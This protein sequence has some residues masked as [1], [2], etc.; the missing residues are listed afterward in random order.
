MA[1]ELVG[2]GPDGSLLFISGKD[3]FRYDIALDRVIPL[4]TAS[5]FGA[6]DTASGSRFMTSWARGS[7]HKYTP[8][9]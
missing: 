9:G 3:L 4:T 2:T 7:A 8:M 6:A 1:H 5:F